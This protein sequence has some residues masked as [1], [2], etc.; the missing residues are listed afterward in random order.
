MHHSAVRCLP[1]KALAGGEGGEPVVLRCQGRLPFTVRPPWALRIQPTDRVGR[2][3]LLP[4]SRHLL[5]GTCLGFK[6]SL[7]SRLCPCPVSKASP[8]SRC[9][10]CLAGWAPLHSTMVAPSWQ[11]SHSDGFGKFLFDLQNPVLQAQCQGCKA[12]RPLPGVPFLLGPALGKLEGTFFCLLLYP[13]LAGPHGTAVP[14][15]QL[16]A[17][18]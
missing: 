14:Q 7:C 5:S 10:P 8:T 16:V 6:V 1:G 11:A 17:Q 18:P 15:G 3:S 9:S 12:P 2:R 13:P 4:A